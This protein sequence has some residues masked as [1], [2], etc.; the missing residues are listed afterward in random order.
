M[1]WGGKLEHAQLVNTCTTDNVLTI[2][3]LIYN[4]HETFRNR[5][6]S[7]GNNTFATFRTVLML[8]EEE[9]FDETKFACVNSISSSNSRKTI[10]LFGDEPDCIM[11]VLDREWKSGTVSKYQNSSFDNERI[12]SKDCVGFTVR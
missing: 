3:H 11:N 2:L 6:L 8:M 9:N 12:E 10:D 4:K 5:L 7:E 1:P